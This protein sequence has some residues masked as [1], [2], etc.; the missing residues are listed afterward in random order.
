MFPNL[1][2]ATPIRKHS[3]AISPQSL[4]CWHPGGSYLL[5]VGVMLALG[6][7]WEAG[8]P[9]CQTGEK[10]YFVHVK[11]FP[12]S[13][14]SWWMRRAWSCVLE[15]T[16]PLWILAFCCL[17]M[18]PFPVP[19]SSRTLILGDTRPSVWLAVTACKEN[20]SWWSESIMITLGLQSA[21]PLVSILLSVAYLLMWLQGCVCDAVGAACTWTPTPYPVGPQACVNYWFN[22][23]TP[24]QFFFPLEICKRRFYSFFA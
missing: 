22:C 2:V 1:G 3:W 21:T 9:P 4:H 20:C 6:K 12:F 13:C 7:F 16:R 18:S 8:S 24:L 19:A 14:E 11:H 5:R 23:L 15:H 17:C 10:S